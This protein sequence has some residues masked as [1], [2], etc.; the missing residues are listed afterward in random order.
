MA[1]ESDDLESMRKQ[2][3]QRTTS[4]DDET[5]R[6]VVKG[7]DCKMYT[8]DS[9]AGIRHYQF[10][11]AQV[12]IDYWY[13]DITPEKEYPMDHNERMKPTIGC[14]YCHQEITLKT[15][16]YMFV[17]HKQHYDHDVQLV[18]CSDVCPKAFTTAIISKCRRCERDYL[19]NIYDED[20]CQLC[21]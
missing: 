5:V 10:L 3:E 15:G 14:L 6:N 11:H 8:G 7:E 1:S 18:T 2:K 4:D 21:K 20:I 12:P 17:Q 13:E 9:I 16:C 19:H